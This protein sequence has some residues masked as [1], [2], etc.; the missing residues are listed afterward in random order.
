MLSAFKHDFATVPRYMINRYILGAGFFSLTFGFIFLWSDLYKLVMR[1]IIGAEEM[2]IELSSTPLKIFTFHTCAVTVRC[3]LSGILIVDK[4]TRL[5][6]L[7]GPIRLCT[8]LF[9]GF[10]LVNVFGVG[11]ATL[12]LAALFSGFCAEAITVFV[13]FVLNVKRKMYS[14]HKKK[15]SSC[16]IIQNV[17]LPLNTHAYRRTSFGDDGGNVEEEE[18]L[19]MEKME[20]EILSRK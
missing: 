5:L 1:N 16:E 15:I 3:I 8:I 14:N 7:P 2:L 4:E 19:S 17:F 11:G 20:F 9:V 6:Y 18:S 12:G 13:Q 10:V